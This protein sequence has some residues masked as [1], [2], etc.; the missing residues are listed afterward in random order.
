MHENKIA[1]PGI[2]WAPLFWVHS[3]EPPWPIALSQSVEIRLKL[4][5]KT[6]RLVSDFRNFCFVSMANEQT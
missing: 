4:Q 5:T 6:D 2:I 1:T 3:D